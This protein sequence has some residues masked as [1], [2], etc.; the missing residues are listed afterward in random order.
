MAASRRLAASSA[1]APSSS[2]R[3]PA[4]KP[5]V[6]SRFS[7]RVASCEP[8]ALV[9]GVELVRLGH[10]EGLA[11]RTSRRS[12]A[13]VSGSGG[14]GSEAAGLASMIAPDVPSETV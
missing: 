13:I 2:T 14:T 7:G 12:R 6:I 1:A 3:P 4:A 9:D 8:S 11:A 5:A 10:V